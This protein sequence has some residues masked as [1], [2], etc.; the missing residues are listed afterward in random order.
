MPHFIDLPPQRGQNPLEQETGSG[1]TIGQVPSASPTQPADNPLQLEQPE[2]ALPEKAFD[3]DT[4]FMKTRTSGAGR[5]TA[6]HERESTADRLRAAS[7]L[8]M[9]SVDT[10]AR[11]VLEAGS[12]TADAILRY[13]YDKRLDGVRTAYQSA[14]DTTKTSVEEYF[15]ATPFRAPIAAGLLAA[16]AT[17]GVLGGF[18][19]HPAM[20][21]ITPGMTSHV[22]QEF[23]LIFSGVE[24]LTSAGLGLSAAVA[25]R[26]KIYERTVE[27]NEE[28]RAAGTAVAADTHDIVATPLADAGRERDGYFMPHSP[29]P[30]LPAVAADNLAHQA[31]YVTALNTYNTA[32]KAGGTVDYDPPLLSPGEQQALAG[33][34]V[35]DVLKPLHAATQRLDELERVAALLAT[36]PRDSVPSHRNYRFVKGRYWPNLD[37][38][39]TERDSLQN[40]D[41]AVWPVA[42]ERVASEANSIAC[43]LI[44]VG[45]LAGNAE[46]L[47]TAAEQSLERYP[48]QNAPFKEH[49]RVARTLLHPG[50]TDGSPVVP[51]AVM[52]TMM[53]RVTLETEGLD[54]KASSTPIILPGAESPTK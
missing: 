14:R 7:R 35:P 20:E 50:D 36:S 43:Y 24:G 9:Q 27:E 26:R 21:G 8:W 29:Y 6:R 3:N 12:E 2:M 45:K 15:I 33:R 1:L 39:R 5:Y 19:T 52:A 25:R 48:V 40:V 54:Y 18:S 23:N 46:G 10:T 44:N 30:H 17:F 38:A 47:L 51:N 4:G 49:I 13:D 42:A 32:T 28:L 41:T 31:Q 34:T 53:L 22:A 16:G 37:D 11:L